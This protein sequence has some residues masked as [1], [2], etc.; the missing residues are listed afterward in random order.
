ML[1]RMAQSSLARIVLVVAGVAAWLLA[2]AFPAS[3]ATRVR[4]PVSSVLRVSGPGLPGRGS[5]SGTVAPRDGSCVGN[6]EITPASTVQVKVPFAHGAAIPPQLTVTCGGTPVSGAAVDLSI[7]GPA[8]FQGVSGNVGDITADSNGAIKLPMVMS[9]LTATGP[10]SIVATYLSASVTLTG[11]VSGKLSGD[12]PPPTNPSLN[13]TTGTEAVNCPGGSSSC[14]ELAQYNGFRQDEDLEPLVLPS[15]WSMLT[16]PQQLFVLTQLERTARGLPPESGLASDW[17]QIAQQGAN[18]ASDPEGSGT[19]T[20]YYQS[21][22]WRYDTDPGASYSI[23]GYGSIWAGPTDPLYAFKLWM[24]QDGL[25][26]NGTSLKR[27]L[28]AE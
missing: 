9:G 17:D 23:D 27:G 18:T 4:R 10:F 20:P 2:T 12:P 19:V 15:N 16:I 22:P 13:E 26:S 1:D 25:N 7:S 28:H 5:S 24:Y 21:S 6:P 11:E 3:S 8:S 14:E